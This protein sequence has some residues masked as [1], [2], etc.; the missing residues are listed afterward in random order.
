[1]TTE[2]LFNPTDRPQRR[3]LEGH[4]IEGLSWAECD[5]DAPDVAAALTAGT[6]VRPTPSAPAPART[7][8]HT[9]PLKES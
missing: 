4:I 1:M 7:R 3:T 5:T 9:T 8:R 6:L 2:R